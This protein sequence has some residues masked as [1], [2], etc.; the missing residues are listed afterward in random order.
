M[1]VSA[2]CGNSILICFGLM[3][4]NMIEALIE[5]YIVISAGVIMM[6]FWGLQLDQ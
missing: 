3:A 1:I 5:S 2:L 4:A 6:G